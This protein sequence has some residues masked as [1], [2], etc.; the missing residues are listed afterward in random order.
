MRF[1]LVIYSPG[2]PLR[3]REWMAARRYAEAEGWQEQSIPTR[4]TVN[5]AKAALQG[6]GD[7]GIQWRRRAIAAFAG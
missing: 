3:V 1:R 5:G 2:R 4:S 7:S 6:A